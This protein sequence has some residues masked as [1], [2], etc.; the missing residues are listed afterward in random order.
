[1]VQLEGAIEIKEGFEDIDFSNDGTHDGWFFSMKCTSR[2]SKASTK[3]SILP[4]AYLK[5]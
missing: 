1:M 5:T 2:W 4:Q 3:C